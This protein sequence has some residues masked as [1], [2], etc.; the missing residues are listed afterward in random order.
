[1][2]TVGEMPNYNIT[3]EKIQTMFNVE[4]GKLKTEE[5]L[6]FSHERIKEN[7]RSRWDWNK[8]IKNIE[9]T[10]LKYGDSLSSI[11]VDTWG[12]DFGILGKD[13]ELLENQYHT[14]MDTIL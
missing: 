9:N 7:G 12:V 11:G 3:T 6:R 5:V 8:I 2:E 4:D 1:M 14:E 10:I 13:G